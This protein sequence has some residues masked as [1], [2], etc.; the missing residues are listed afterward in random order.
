MTKPAIDLTDQRF[1]K[2]V[3]IRRVS[4]DHSN[5]SQWECQCD[6][7]ITKIIRSSSLKNGITKSCGC[8]RR[9]VNRRNNIT[10]GDS[11]SVEYQT[12]NDIRKRCTNPNDQAWKYYGGRG[13][14][15]CKEWVDDYLAFLTH[16]GRRPSSQHT[17]D[18]IDNDGDY[19][20]GNVR[21]A[22]KIEQRY[23]Q[24]QRK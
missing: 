7:G 23:N 5:L 8:L 19:K 12:W 24:R 21:W 15:V 18:R 17:I 1:G 11:N 2:L 20:P 16:I 14:Q 4:N 10:H 3:V 13:I 9:E 6:C 22:T